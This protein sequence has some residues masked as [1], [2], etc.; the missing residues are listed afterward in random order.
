MGTGD[1]GTRW[2]T[3]LGFA[4][5]LGAAQAGTLPPYGAGYRPVA[6]ARVNRSL[7]CARSS[8]ERL[9]QPVPVPGGLRATSRVG[10]SPASPTA[11]QFRGQF[12][13]QAAGDLLADAT[14]KEPRHWPPGES[15]YLPGR[16]GATIQNRRLLDSS[17]VYWAPQD[18]PPVAWLPGRSWVTG[19]GRAAIQWF[20]ADDGALQR[21]VGNGEVE[22]RST[23]GMWFSD[24][25][26]MI[27]DDPAKDYVQRHPKEKA[28]VEAEASANK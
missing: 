13:V 21:K 8:A 20:L 25:R 11:A 14:L 1:R 26:V 4:V 6:P 7:A 23:S 5:G 18:N 24:D 27:P 19:K 10:P 15:K 9:A 16:E 12:G 17:F 28:A 3:R 2:L 22:R